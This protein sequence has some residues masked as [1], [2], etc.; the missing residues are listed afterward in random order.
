MFRRFATVLAVPESSENV[1]RKIRNNR[2]FRNLPSNPNVPKTKSGTIKMLKL[3]NKPVIFNRT[4][5][6]CSRKR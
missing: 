6:K 3:L 5:L 4:F 2:N 1:T